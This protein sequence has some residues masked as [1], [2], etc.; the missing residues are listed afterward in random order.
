M[1]LYILVKYEVFVYLYVNKITK[2]KVHPKRPY[3]EENIAF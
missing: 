2:C 3:F 1:S